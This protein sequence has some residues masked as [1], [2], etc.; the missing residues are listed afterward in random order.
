MPVDDPPTQSHVRATSEGSRD[1]KDGGHRG[2]EAGECP[3]SLGHSSHKQVSVL[4][5]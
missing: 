1:G 4:M 2:A 5:H 3:V